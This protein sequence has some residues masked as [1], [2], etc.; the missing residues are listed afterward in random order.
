MFGRGGE[1]RCN[2]LLSLGLIYPLITIIVS[3][4]SQLRKYKDSV[5]MLYPVGCVAQWLERRSLAGELSLSCA[6]PA[7]DG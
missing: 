7:T 5:D 3:R 4:N 6:R 2:M 1:G